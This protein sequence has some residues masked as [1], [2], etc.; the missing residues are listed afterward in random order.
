MEAA[1]EALE[2]E[3]AV[4][5]RDR[6]AL[7]R[8][9]QSQQAIYKLKGE[10]DILSIAY[11]AGVTCVQIM[12]VRNGKMLGGKSYFPDMLSDDLGQ[13]LADFIANFYFQ[14]ADDIPA[15]LIV[16]V[17]VADRQGLE[18]ALTQHVKKKQQY[19][20]KVRETRAGWLELAK[21]VVLQAIQGKQ[22][23]HFE[24]NGLLHQMQH[25][26]RRPVVRT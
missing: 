9:V 2:F 6:M 11:Q 26:V 21:M 10:A 22:A 1:A 4:F 8:D 20:S 14:V 13:M 5:Y 16:N 12:H 15:E 25:V 24:Q 19:N 23:N 7:L 3:K 18:A 17:E